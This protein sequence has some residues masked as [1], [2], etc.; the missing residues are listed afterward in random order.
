M[1]IKIAVVIVLLVIIGSLISALFFLV[2]DKRGTDR[3]V[4]AL[5]F[6][7]SLSIFLFTMLVL[8]A[9]FGLVGHPL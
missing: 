6:R 3:T 1:W 9:H 8:A 7:I 2:K 5:T 4:K